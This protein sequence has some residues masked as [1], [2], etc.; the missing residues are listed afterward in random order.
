MRTSPLLAALSLICLPMLVS[1]PAH[2]QANRTWVSGGGDD[3]NPCSRTV[4]C[5]TFAGA[6]SKT[7]AGGIINCLDPGSFGT[8]TITKSITIDCRETFAGVQAAGTSGINVNAVGIVVILRGLSIEGAGTGT[9]GVIVSQA[10][11]VHI[12]KCK[13]F[14]F[15]AGASQG[16]RY[17]SSNGG[18]LFVRDTV[19]SENGLGILALAGAGSA[20]VTLQRVQMESNGEGFR[21]TGAGGGVVFVDVQDSLASTNGTN[22]FIATT[23]GGAA[24]TLDI[25]RSSSNLNGGAG[26]QA[27]G[28]AGAQVFIGTSMVTANTTGFSQTNGGVIRSYGNNTVDNNTS[29][30]AA[31]GPTL[32]QM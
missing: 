14:G 9:S 10:N 27:D 32:G 22:G 8:V 23:G 6:I 3:I 1:D 5:K 15:Q 11:S 30:G 17:V 19:L 29:N 24:V 25:Q 12:E 4:P 7:A 16:I 2:A 13:I 26:I 28:G 20:L 21:A 31:T 18:S